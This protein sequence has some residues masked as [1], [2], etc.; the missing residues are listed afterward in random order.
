M[1][2]VGAFV[3]LYNFDVFSLKTYISGRLLIY[4]VLGITLVETI[5]CGLSI[6][7]INRKIENDIISLSDIVGGDVKEAY[8]YAQI[9]LIV[10]NEEG[11]VLW[12]SDL[13]T[14][15][16]VDIIGKSVYEWAPALRSKQTN[17]NEVT[18][19][20]NERVYQTTFL[21]NAGL[22]IF[23]DI[24]DYS[25]LDKYAKEQSL[26]LGVIVIDNYDEI[27]GATD[28]VSDDIAEVRTIITKYFSKNGCILR[29]YRNDAYFVVCNRLVLDK[30]IKDNFSVSTD[31]RNIETAADKI[32]PTI[33]IGFAY[34]CDDFVKLN[35]IASKA[36]DVALSRGG[37]QV[38]LSRYG[39]DLQFIGGRSEATEQSSRVK[40]RVVADSLIKDIQK[41]SNVLIMG[42][43]ELDMDALGSC[44]GVK[45]ICNFLN[46]E[47]RVIYDPKRA[48]RKTRAA[49]AS[50]FD[51]EKISKMICSPKAALDMVDE[52]TLVIV[53]DVS[54]PRLTFCPKLLEKTNN[55]IILD[56]HR[57]ANDFIENNIFYYIDPSASSAS[58]IIAQMIKYNS[59]KDSIPMEPMVATVMLSGIFL[60]S[61]YYKSKTTG[62]G[63]FEA[64]MILKEY[65]ADNGISDDLLKD[66]FEEFTLIN[67][68]MNT[69]ETPFFGIAVCVVD[70]EDVIDRSTLSKVANRCVA[71]KGIE[72][73]FCI[74]RTG[75][76]EVR[77]S[78]RSNGFINVQYLMEKVG[79]GGHFGSA[80]AAFVSKDVKEVKEQLLD[81]LSDHLSQARSKTYKDE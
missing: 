76:N 18:L 51:R 53:V 72:A 45:T 81:A 61:G 32:K 25:M 3:V 27:V 1:T 69:I 15:R 63:T 64:S 56:H 50:Q 36:V 73:S 13:L 46:V 48:E 60:D 17:D 57:R 59:L 37:D 79:G 58:E 12:V 5:L 43:D 42:H 30:L 9:G 80:A 65:G 19:T 41:A 4:F 6:F 66:D 74:G 11:I 54:V 55:I 40:L 78:A 49:F 77:I 8:L 21:K 47:S 33:S 62:F 29:S 70:E 67:K 34:E 71:L 16:N 52:N 10:V 22:Y 14:Q 31:I 35:E 38:V 2:L 26:C 39:T 44:L 20:I 24:T 7:I 28:V 23:K 68:I 75:E